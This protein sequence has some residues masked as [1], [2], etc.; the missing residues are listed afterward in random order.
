V[1]DLFASALGAFVMIA[2]ILFPYYLKDQEARAKES[3]ASAAARSGETFL[4]VSADWTVEGADIDLYVTDPQGREYSFSRPNRGPEAVGEAHLSYDS[5]TG[6]G[7]EIW[8]SAAAQPG[9]YRVEYRLHS[10]PAGGEPV[11]VKGQ[12]FERGGRQ[13]LPPRT[14]RQRGERQLAAV[15]AVAADGRLDVR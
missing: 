15:V 5:R 14:L 9:D 6:P 2:V 4:V 11:E 7:M 12:I 1:L 3:D 13:A 10:A 8:Q